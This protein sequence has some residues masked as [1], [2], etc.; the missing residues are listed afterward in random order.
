MYALSSLPPKPS[1]TTCG[2][3]SFTPSADRLE[4]VEHVGAREPGRDAAVDAADRLD[5]GA[6]AGRADDRVARA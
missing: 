2:L 3:S 1:T 6:R 4:P 5:R